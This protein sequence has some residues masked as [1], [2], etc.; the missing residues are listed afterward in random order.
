MSPVNNG[1][2]T[3]D[4]LPT[5][6]ILDSLAGRTFRTKLPV[7]TL[8]TSLASVLVLLLGISLL[9]HLFLTPRV[10]VDGITQEDVLG[11]NLIEEHNITNTEVLREIEALFNRQSK[12]LA[13]ASARYTLKTGQ[14]P[15]PKY[16]EWFSFASKRKCLIDE[17]DQIHRDL[18]P[19]YQ[20]IKQDRG[21]EWYS[22]RIKRVRE[23]GLSDGGH[24]QSGL[25]P[26]SIRGG[27]YIESL[28]QA[29]IVKEDWDQ[30]MN[31]E[32]VS[33]SEYVT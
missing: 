33:G 31:L 4:G 19:F 26:A 28:G 24:W 30:I 12:T 20:V 21:I 7:R 27:K 5:Y 9:F 3:S 6:R 1:E 32:R 16:S 2:R 10:I 17:Y 8:A 15:P 11:D 18:A 22:G 25:I 14:Q 29:G 13:Q 23:L